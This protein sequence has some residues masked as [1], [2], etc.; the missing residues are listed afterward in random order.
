[1]KKKDPPV[2]EVKPH[3]YQ[4]SKAELEADM[5]IDATPEDV[6]RAAMKQVTVKEIKDVGGGV[7]L[8]R[9]PMKG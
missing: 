4:P 2:V 8:D 1:M 9:S 6:A 5:S 3:T 7:V